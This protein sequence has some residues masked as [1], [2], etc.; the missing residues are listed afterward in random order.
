MSRT[1]SDEIA[2]KLMAGNKSVYA[3]NP[4]LTR[5]SIVINQIVDE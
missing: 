2:T 1:I 4:T 3:I 5:N